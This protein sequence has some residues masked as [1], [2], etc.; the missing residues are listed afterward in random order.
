MKRLIKF[1]S[2]NRNDCNPFSWNHLSHSFRLTLNNEFDAMSATVC[3]PQQILIVFS[4]FHFKTAI[5]ISN[6]FHL[7]N[8]YFFPSSRERINFNISFIISLNINSDTKC[9]QF[10]FLLFS[11]FHAKFKY[12]QNVFHYSFYVFNKSS[13]YRARFLLLH[14][15]HDS[16]M[17]KN[18]LCSRIWVC[19]VLWTGHTN[20]MPLFEIQHSFIGPQNFNTDLILCR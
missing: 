4:M 8:L 12:S 17:T 2:R 15:F 19:N 9:E 5:L 13:M 11:K 18:G 14:D 16:H 1:T 3:G 6:Q 7:S 20:N 10:H